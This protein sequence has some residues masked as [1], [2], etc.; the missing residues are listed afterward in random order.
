[1]IRK[2]VTTSLLYA[3][4][5]GVIL[6]WWYAA[7]A[8]S[9]SEPI[10]SIEQAVQPTST[11]LFST[12][13]TLAPIDRPV[14]HKA[15]SGDIALMTQLIADWDIDAQLL[16]VTGHKNAKRLSSPSYLRSQVIGR[17]LL[18]ANAS[19]SNSH[20]PKLLPQTYVSASFLLALTDHEQIVALPKGLREQVLLFAPE[21]T[22]KIP[23]DV[24]RYNAETLY[25]AQPEIAFIAHY[26]HP[27]LVQALKNQGTELVTL[28]AE[29]TIA[30]IHQSI[31]Q[32]GAIANRPLEAELLSLFM[33]AA[34]Q[35]IDNR[36]LLVENSLLKDPLQRILFVNYHTQY[37]LPTS[38]TMTG[39]ILK[40]MGIRNIS[41]DG[42]FANQGDW[43]IPLNREQL[44]CIDPQCLII[45]SPSPQTVKEHISNDP[46]LSQLAAAKNH[47][48]YFVDEAVQQF[49]SQYLVLAYFDIAQALLE[50]QL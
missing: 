31:Q 38:R 22:N 47:R 44:A 23:L 35:A 20:R 29:N 46:A 7:F 10:T 32:I 18:Q 11:R 50:T 21:K 43:L 2:A 36:L 34:M 5:A 39:Q 49:P 45:A 14:L 28:T 42:L 24:D 17:Q 3:T 9:S 25:M 19:S 33:E 48:I 41:M 12:L 1:M 30:N 40:R 13:G 4:S 16:E 26:S 37:S 15:L 8:P 27:A 6:G